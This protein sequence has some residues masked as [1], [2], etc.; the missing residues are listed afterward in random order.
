MLYLIV[1]PR[2]IRNPALLPVRSVAAP[3]S[4]FRQRPISAIIR[5]FPCA[6]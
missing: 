3:D 5:R 6:A 4:L 1:I 2:D